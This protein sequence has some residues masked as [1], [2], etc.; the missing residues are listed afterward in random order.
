MRGE[1]VHPTF[2]TTPVRSGKKRLEGMA[3]TANPIPICSTDDAEAK[4]V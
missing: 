3:T 2:S 1:T 4:M